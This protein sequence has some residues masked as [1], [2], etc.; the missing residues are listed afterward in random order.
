MCNI[1][2]CNTW[3]YYYPAT[4]LGGWKKCNAYVCR[5]LPG[6]TILFREKYRVEIFFKTH[7][8][9]NDIFGKKQDSLCRGSTQHREIRRFTTFFRGGAN[10][11]FRLRRVFEKLFFAS[12][13]ERNC[14][15]PARPFPAAN[16]RDETPEAT[17]TRMMDF[18]F[19]VL[20]Y[21]Q[22]S[23]AAAFPRCSPT[24]VAFP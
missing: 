9:E 3:N 19:K 14:S 18:L 5:K 16:L 15:C 24:T 12:R 23:L 8:R 10:I 2:I 20:N 17:A 4:H 7:F 21:Q 22:A 6:K 1:T 11:C 13:N